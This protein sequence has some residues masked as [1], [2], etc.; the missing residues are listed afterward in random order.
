[1]DEDDA[2]PED[3]RESKDSDGDGEGDNAD[4]DDDNDGW[5]DIDEL[6]QGSNPFSSSEQ[7]VEGFELI[8]PGTQ[9]SLGAWHIIGIFTG[10]PLAL[11]ICAGL[12]TRV[13]RGRRYE[14]ALE[15]ATSIDELNQVAAEYESSLMWKMIGPH[16][17]LR[18]ERMR[19]EIERDKFAHS[20]K[21]VPE[22]TVGQKPTE[23]TVPPDHSPD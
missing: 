22:I 19:T 5:T 20:S 6:R 3:F 10:V 23:S 8:I 2:F 1:M 14:Q 15:E 17:G 21:I 12:L 4:V 9:V 11:W 7:P 16:Q 13:E 18:L